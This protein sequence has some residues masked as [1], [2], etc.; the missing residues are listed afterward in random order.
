MAWNDER[1]ELFKDN[2]LA[3]L[4]AVLL[5]ALLGAIL[6]LASRKGA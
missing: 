3:N 2:V 4:V 5:L 1:K 6:G